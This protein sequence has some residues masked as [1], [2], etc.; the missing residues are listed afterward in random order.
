VRYAEL[1]DRLSRELRGIEISDPR[2]APLFR[3]KLAARRAVNAAQIIISEAP[4]VHQLGNQWALI[5]D[6]FDTC[7]SAQTESP[8]PGGS[9]PTEGSQL[10][11]FWG[12]LD[13]QIL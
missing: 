7:G 13:Y 8:R 12:A 1:S 10:K 3:Q 4:L 2:F 6:V 5:K 9:I 11:S